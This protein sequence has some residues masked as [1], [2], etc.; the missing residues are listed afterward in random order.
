MMKKSQDGLKRLRGFHCA[1]GSGFFREFTGVIKT[2]K[3]KK[4][5]LQILDMS[6]LE[7]EDVFS[8]VLGGSILGRGNRHLRIRGRKQ[9]KGKRSLWKKVVFT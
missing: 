9:G 7:I 3:Y 5:E 8:I 2:S 1:D 6:Q 4:T